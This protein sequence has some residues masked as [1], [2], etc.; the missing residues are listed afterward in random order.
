MRPQDTPFINFG[1]IKFPFCLHPNLLHDSL[2]ALINHGGKRINFLQLKGLPGVLQT[3]PGPF[4]S[5]PLTPGSAGQA[6]TNLGTRSKSCGEV[7]VHKS[8]EPD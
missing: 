8:D 3:S 1:M 4:G 2:R 6:P 5:V 7:G